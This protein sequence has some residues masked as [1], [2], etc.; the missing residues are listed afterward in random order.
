[1]KVGGL[2][3][4]GAE[5]HEARRIDNQLRGRAGRQGDPG[6][7]RFFLSLEDDLLRI[8]GSENITGLMQKL[9]MEEGV[10]IESKL[11]TR[12]IERA[13]SQVEA[14]NFEIR[15]HLLEYDDVMNKQREEI[16]R[17]RRELLEGEDQ[18]EYV[19]EMADSLVAGLLQ[20]YVSEDVSPEEWDL[21]NLNVNYLRLFGIKLPEKAPVPG[22]SGSDG[23]EAVP[24]T[25]MS[26]PELDQLLIDLLEAR[27]EQKEEELTPE[28]MRWFERVIMLQILDQHWKDHLLALDHLKE[29][30]GLRGYG[31]KDPKIEY[32]RESFGLFEELTDAVA[33]EAVRMLFLLKPEVKGPAEQMLPRR[34]PSNVHYSGTEAET[35]GA[36]GAMAQASAAERPEARGGGQAVA[37]ETV[38]RG[39]P[40]VGRNDP[41]PCGSGKK[42]KKCCGR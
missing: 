18:K 2:K 17:F 25:E 20:T 38:R 40:K 31:Q 42:F 36:G 30:I 15:K 3:I 27:Y 33:E 19:L 10:P 21:E 14:R 28:V 29:G 16:Y 9:G 13:Q 11:L 39:T 6:S 34:S 8:F 24:L 35:A 41:C 7:S 12:Q 1:V 37:V 5:R 26:R 23:N 32:K 22:E 4:I